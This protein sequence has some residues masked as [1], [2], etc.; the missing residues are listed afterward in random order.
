MAQRVFFFNRLHD[1]T[2]RAEYEDWIRRV[3]YP[4]ARKQDAIRSYVVTRLDG[5]LSG[6]GEP[7]YHYLETIEITDINAYRAIDN[8]EF[9]QLLEEWSTYV[10]ES[11]MVYGEVIE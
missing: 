6:E 2:D 4:I 1:N 7:P 3:D 9:K 10:A 8:P 5:M 11:V